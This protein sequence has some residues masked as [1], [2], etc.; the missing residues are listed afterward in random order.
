MPRPRMRSSF[1]LSDPGGTFSDTGPSGVGA[2]TV[3]LEKAAP[4][5]L[6]ASTRALDDG[7]VLHVAPGFALAADGEVILP[8]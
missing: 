6:L 2:S 8:C 5:D 3:L 1:P 4:D 7:T